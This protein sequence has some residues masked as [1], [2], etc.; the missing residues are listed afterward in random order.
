VGMLAAALMLVVVSPG[1]VVPVDGDELD[2]S[3]AVVDDVVVVVVDDV[4]ELVVDELVV[5]VSSGGTSV[6]CTSH[7]ASRIVSPAGQFSPG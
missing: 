4:V 7:A 6:S 1:A 5:V 2:G 3:D